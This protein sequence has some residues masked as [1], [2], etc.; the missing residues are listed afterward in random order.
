MT[1]TESDSG[2]DIW[3]FRGTQGPRLPWVSRKTPLGLQ[4]PSE[5]RL[6]AQNGAQIDGATAKTD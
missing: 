6:R 3:G 1:P 2:P 4:L 5:N